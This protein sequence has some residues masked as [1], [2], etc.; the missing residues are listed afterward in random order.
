MTSTRR[1]AFPTCAALIA[2]AFLAAQVPAQAEGKAPAAPG[3]K[4]PV[5][6]LN[7]FFP[8]DFSDAAYQK[9]AFQRVLSAWTPK[10]PT[11]PA[12][13]KTVVIARIGKDGKLV[14]LDFN[15][16]SGQASF[17]ASALD[18]VKKAA[19]FHPIP[20]GYRASPLEIHF[21]FEVGSR[22]PG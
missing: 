10:G 21:H 16:Q 22:V 11:P 13:K 3:A 2:L 6:K 14:G 12:G 17:D 19:P 15:L 9:D 5:L 4:A 18:A 8:A 7:V 20:A 1:K